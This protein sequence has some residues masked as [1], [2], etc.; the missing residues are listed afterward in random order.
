MTEAPTALER[1]D[2]PVLLVD[3]GGVLLLHNHELLAPITA[4]YGGV[5]TAE[6][7]QRAHYAAHNV[8]RPAHGPE[9]NYYDIFGEYAGIPADRRDEFRDEYV[10][11]HRTRNMCHWP[12]P[13]AKRALA[14]I[15][16]DGI[17]VVVVSQADGTIDVAAERKRLAK[18][19]AVDVRMARD[20]V[21]LPRFEM[22]FADGWGAALDQLVAIWGS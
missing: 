16:D 20:Q 2:G 4:R 10:A 8:S 3:V 6:D 13:E 17:P 14:A 12:D 1:S 18:D 5:A 11:F 7:F 21:L 22:G 9:I 15:V 19:L